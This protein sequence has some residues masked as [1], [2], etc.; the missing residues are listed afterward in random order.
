MDSDKADE[1]PYNPALRYEFSLLDGLVIIYS[2]VG[3]LI[4]HQKV[5]QFHWRCGGLVKEA[6]R[7]GRSRVPL[8]DKTM[9]FRY[10]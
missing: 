4:R 7:A 1:A 8:Y 3:L 9:L 5:C 10:W 6:L 2:D